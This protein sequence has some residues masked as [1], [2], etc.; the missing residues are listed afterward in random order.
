LL[1]SRKIPSKCGIPE[2]W[3]NPVVTVKDEQDRFR[4]RF[5]WIGEAGS[6]MGRA[7]FSLA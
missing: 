6:G 4:V 2:R 7:C 5:G 1:K 3:E